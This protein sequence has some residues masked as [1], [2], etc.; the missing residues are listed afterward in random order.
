MSPLHRILLVAAHAAYVA[1]IAFPHVLPSSA[2]AKPVTRSLS[3]RAVAVHHVKERSVR[4]LKSKDSKGK[5][6]VPHDLYPSHTNVSYHRHAHS[7]T[8]LH[9]PA[10]AYG[11]SGD[12]NI[13]VVTQNINILNNYYSNACNSAKALSAHLSPL[14]IKRAEKFGAYRGVYFSAVYFKAKEQIQI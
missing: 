9:V 3:S 11:R 6:A 1:L 7:S 14:L 8:G 4:V 12:I 5:A 2:L 13:D 10:A